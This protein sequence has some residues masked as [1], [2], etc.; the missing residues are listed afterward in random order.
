M[1]RQTHVPATDARAASKK[2]E[3]LE[4]VGYSVDGRLLVDER[5]PLFTSISEQLS[6]P[7]CST[8]LFGRWRFKEVI[9]PAVKPES[10]PGAAGRGASTTLIFRSQRGSGSRH[11]ARGPP[12]LLASIWCASLPASV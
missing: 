5:D 11:L 9:A 6:M 10:L 3:Q 8:I 1:V 4:L 2:E 7:T 12:P